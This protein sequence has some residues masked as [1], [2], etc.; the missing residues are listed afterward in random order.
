[1]KTNNSPKQ[2]PDAYRDW[3]G[4]F[5]DLATTATE[6][7]AVLEPQAKAPT[8]RLLRYYQ[9][10]GV[11]GRGEKQG[12]RAL[13]TFA[14]LERVVAAKGLVQQNWTLDNAA[15]LFSSAGE[16]PEAVS[17]LLYASPTPMSSAGP[18]LNASAASGL[19][20]AHP[21]G[22]EDASSV[23]ARL[24]A[25]SHGL[26]SP[27]KSVRS[28]GALGGQLSGVVSPAIASGLSGQLNASP[29]QSIRPTPW[30]TVYLDE[31]AAQGATPAERAQA[32]VSLEALLKTLR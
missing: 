13:F 11:L 24:M 16:H 1:M 27:H 5:R 8:E 7:L 19:E 12:N 26:S 9:H 17:A 29:V 28:L 20:A 23:V 15:K 21:P 14:D 2:W 10:Q 22:G 32:C 25:T 3:T 6:V 18:A 4:T 31:A 30:L